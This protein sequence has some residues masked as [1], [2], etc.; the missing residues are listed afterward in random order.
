MKKNCFFL[1]VLFF[2][3][4]SLHGQQLRS[5]ISGTVTSS[6]GLPMAGASIVVE[7]LHSGVVAGNS[8]HYELRGLKNG[9]YHIR[10]SFTGYEPVVRETVLSRSVV[11]DITLNE[12]VVMTDEVVVSST[13]AGSST[14]VAYSDVDA[15]GIQ[16]NDMT[17]DMP[18]LLALTPSVVETS[19]AGTGVGYTS[20]RVRGSGGSRI[21]VTLDG[22]PL[23]DAESQ[24]MFWV[25]LPDLASSVSSIQMQRGI[26]TS[27]NGAGAFGAS[28]NINTLTPPNEAGAEVN[29]SAGSFNTFKT[30]VKGYT[31]RLGDHFSMALR[32]SMIKSDGFIKHSGSDIKSGSVSTAWT[33]AR[34]VIRANALMGS[35]RTGIAWWGVPEEMLSTDRRYNPAGEY[36]DANGVT[37]YYNDEVD[38]YLQNHYHLSVNHMLTGKLTFNV[39]LHL[40]TG[41]GY[42]EEQKSDQ[43]LAEYGLE[44]IVIK[45]TTITETDMVERKWMSNTFYGAVWSLTR[46]GAKTDLTLGGGIN[47]YDGDH[48]GKI[49]WMQNAGPYIPGYEWYRNRGLKDEINLYGRTSTEL[50]SSLSSYVDMQLRYISYT[51]KG[52]DDDMHDL[53]LGH[54]FTFFNPKAGLFWRNGTGSEVY[55]S[56]AVAHRE[57]TRSDFTNAAG[58]ASA[59]PKPEKMTDMET[60]YSFKSAPLVF[61]LNIYLMNYHNQLVPTGQ[62][63]NVGYSIM[64]NVEKSYREGIELSTNFTPSKNYGVNANITLSRNKISDFR[65][66]YTEYNTSDWSSIYTYS[67]LGTVDIA[68]SPSVTGSATMEY[69]PA[70]NLSL[71]LTGKYVGKQYYDN[72]MSND[73]KIDPYFVS[74]FS[75]G[76]AITTKSMGEIDMRLQVNNILN[77]KYQ[78]NAYGGMWRED[79]VEKTWAYFFPQAGTNYMFSIGFKL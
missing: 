20:L 40:T 64:T 9:S 31:G 43:T 65:N 68:Y 23:N 5:T 39:S 60:G 57:P 16:R 15:K 30:T 49:L 53:T 38:D 27:T 79:A 56:V 1:V 12:S 58:D 3:A 32:A 51:I 36:T 6:D 78:S 17:R 8:G 63:S 75:A 35:E 29:F 4:V 66:Y 26:G 37:R 34:T 19:D 44:N 7:E 74:N 14:P 52:P 24:E 22:I 10:Y 72:T 69:T 77:N 62:I 73:R 33:S 55:A 28:V 25:D 59:T 54:Y 76:Y 13:R 61:N 71:C 67:D 47:R 50:T 11:I 2:I 70:E 46:K 18:Y 48:F 45:D 21:N 42:Y 41:N